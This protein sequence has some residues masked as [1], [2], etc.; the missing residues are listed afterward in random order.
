MICVGSGVVEFNLVRVGMGGGLS[1]LV[2]FCV[3][4]FRTGRSSSRV[5]GNS[6]IWV[7]AGCGWLALTLQRSG[8]PD[9][10]MAGSDPI[11]GGRSQSGNS[12]CWS[13]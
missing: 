5:A 4:W 3:G 10:A 1:G 7:R 2:G 9:N 11:K 8:V 13:V 12:K 6:P